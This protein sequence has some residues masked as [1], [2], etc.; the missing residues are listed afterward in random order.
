MGSWWE[1]KQ[2]EKPG[3]RLK[4]MLDGIKYKIT[5]NVPFG[6]ATP[7]ISVRYGVKKVSRHPG[8]G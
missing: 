2:E 1:Q 3:G 8:W 6:W 4:Q 7:S 5:M